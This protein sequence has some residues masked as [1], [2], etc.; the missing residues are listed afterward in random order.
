MMMMSYVSAMPF[1]PSPLPLF[2]FFFFFIFFVTGSIP[3]QLTAIS[4]MFFFQSFH[5]LGYSA[6]NLILVF[7]VV[8]AVIYRTLSLHT[9][10]I[11]AQFVAAAILIS[12]AAVPFV[13][14]TNFLASENRRLNDAVREDGGIKQNF[15][16]N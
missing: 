13:M 5:A 14:V 1:S 6:I 10:P 9:K 11:R 16:K 2:L 15:P 8:L 12:V 7:L 3:N 4:T